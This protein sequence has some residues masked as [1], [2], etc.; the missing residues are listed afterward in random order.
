MITHN[1]P[2]ATGEVAHTP[3][4]YIVR[5]DNSIASD[6]WG[7]IAHVCPG[8]NKAIQAQMDATAAFIVRACNSHAALVE[9][10]EDCLSLI[11]GQYPDGTNTSCVQRT[12]DEARAAL[13]QARNS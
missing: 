10:L 8:A 4:P 5:E 1:T 13:A 9:A 12:K 11:D 2:R 6:D 7:T 3:T